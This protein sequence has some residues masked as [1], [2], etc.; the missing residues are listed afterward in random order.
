MLPIKGIL[1]EPVGCLAEFP[2]EPFLEI[3]ARFSGRKQASKSG[4][5]A[6]WHLLNLMQSPAGHSPDALEIEAVEHATLYDDVVPALAELKAMNIQLLIASSLSKAAITRF[7]DKG[8]LRDY[9]ASVWTRDD[10][11]GI[12]AVPLERALESACLQPSEAM[13]L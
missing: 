13:F 6:Y 5:R 11:T 9:F 4:S 12:K 7:L 10:A 1:F 2:P 8:A 3:A